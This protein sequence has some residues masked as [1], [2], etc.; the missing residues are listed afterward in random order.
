[1]SSSDE[2]AERSDGSGHV[3]ASKRKSKKLLGQRT[4]TKAQWLLGADNPHHLPEDLHKFIQTSG[5]VQTALLA[6]AFL[7]PLAVLQLVGV[8]AD[9]LTT[10]IT[11]AAIMGLGV[12]K[13]TLSDNGFSAVHTLT[14]VEGLVS[15]LAATGVILSLLER[16][17]A[18][19][20]PAYIM[21][22]ACIAS[23]AA[24]FLVHRRLTTIAR[25]ANR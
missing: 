13:Y 6:P 5:A 4:N 25:D 1:M 19:S 8:T 22:G 21:F 11:A 14:S 24:S 3:L 10:R 9:E 15:T 20:V 12:C 23:S 16:P 2:D 7:S 17:A 18:R